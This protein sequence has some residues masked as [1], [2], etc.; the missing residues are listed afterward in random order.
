MTYAQAANV[1]TCAAPCCH[2]PA[3]FD[4][5]RIVAGG[6]TIALGYCFECALTAPPMTPPATEPAPA[7]KGRR[8]GRAAR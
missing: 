3:E 2:Q 6:R 4:L 5:I 1:E 7:G 8:R